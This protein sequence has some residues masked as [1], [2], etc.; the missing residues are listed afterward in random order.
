MKH[1]EDR[2]NVA[3]GVN[4]YYQCWVPIGEPKAIVVLV[5]GLAEHSG[6]YGN[7]AN[8]LVSGGYGVY[9]YD[10]R[11]HGKS[12]GLK[13]YVN[14]FSSLV[15]DL[16][17]FLSIV[18][19]R[20]PRAKVF[21]AGHSMGGT[22]ATSY[23]VLHQDRING[24]ILS[25]ALF[26]TPAGTKS[27]IIFAARILSMILPRIGL[28]FIDAES[29]SRDKNVVNAYRNDP[30]VYQGKIC[31]RSGVE[32]IKGMDSVSRQFSKIRLPILVMHGTADRLSAP[33][34]SAIFY[35]K[36]G[37]EDKTLKIYEGFFHEIFNEPEQKQ[38]MDDVTTWLNTHA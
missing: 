15:N 8:Y 33:E 30:Q 37:S 2:F 27:G 19:N 34:D 23:A 25:G 20:H 3:G 38:V 11:G 36:A 24:L 13:G 1:L 17:L 26:S 35:Q 32:L 6:R 7:F 16:D 14:S 31:A 10:Q 9:S 12:D 5:H 4:L 28:Y 21:L 22:I 29:I 18:R